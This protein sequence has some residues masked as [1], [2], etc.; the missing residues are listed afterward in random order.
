MFIADAD[1]AH[2][3][4]VTRC[5]SRYRK[6]EIVGTA[7]DGMTALKHIAR[8]E[9][10]ALLT[11]IQLPGLDGIML[12]KDIR[13]L[14]H[15][16]IS[17]VCTHFYSDFCVTKAN[18]YGACYVLYKPVDYNRL[19]EVILECY[20]SGMAA[21]RSA[22]FASKAAG[23]Q[24]SVV[25]SLL[26]D[27][28]IP[29]KLAGAHYLIESILCLED[30][31]ALM[32]NLSKGLYQSVAQ[33]MHTTPERVE[34]SLRSAISIGYDRG[35]LGKLFPA[36]PTNKAF[37]EYLMELSRSNAQSPAGEPLSNIIL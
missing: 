32:R 21:R 34:R 4:N 19:P 30:D 35:S 31:S 12:L 3:E 15:P 13:L 37:I 22:G 20:K 36:K 14:Q 16:P 10:D 2:I 29:S 25:R 11:D 26:N 9:P 6:I 28:G 23:Q 24:G 7:K 8:D 1:E 17:I 27:M 33:R 18:R 5:V